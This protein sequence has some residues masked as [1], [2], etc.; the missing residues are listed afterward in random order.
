MITRMPV[1]SSLGINFFLVTIGS[2]IDVN[3]A[4]V[5]RKTKAMETLDLAIA[6]KKQY[7]A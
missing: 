5:E 6:T 7:H 4:V 3:S 1:I 2:A